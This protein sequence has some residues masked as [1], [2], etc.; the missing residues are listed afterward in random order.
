LIAIVVAIWS[1]V[2]FINATDEKKCWSDDGPWRTFKNK[3]AKLRLT[4]FLVAAT[5]VIFLPSKTDVAL[6]VGSSIA[7]DM[8]NSPEAAKV[9]TLLRQQ[10]N[11]LL[12]EAI[13]E[14]P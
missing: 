13:K 9:S 8:K 4:L 10:A 2:L 11:K 7:I 12:D 3:T 6:L 14:K 5:F 1:A